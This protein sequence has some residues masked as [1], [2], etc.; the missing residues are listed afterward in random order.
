MDMV[1]CSIHLYGCGHAFRVYRIHKIM[2]ALASTVSSLTSV[3]DLKSSHEHAVRVIETAASNSLD[4][5]CILAVVG[6]DTTLSLTVPVF[7]S[8]W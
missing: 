1:T 2:V 6:H 3:L 4:R 8:L 5:N 7:L